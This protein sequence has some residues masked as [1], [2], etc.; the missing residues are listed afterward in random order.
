VVSHAQ[1][2]QAVEPGTLTLD[3]ISGAVG[4][5]QLLLAWERRSWY[6]TSHC[7]GMVF[8]ISCKTWDSPSFTNSSALGTI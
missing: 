3:E 8:H 2:I 7:L 4:K 5:H 1:T 6:K